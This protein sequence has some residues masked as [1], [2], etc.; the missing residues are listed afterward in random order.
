[1]NRFYMILLAPL[2]LASS[3]FATPTACAPDTLAN[4]LV[5]PGGCTINSVLFNQWSYASAS[6]LASSIEVTPITTPGDEGFNFNSLWVVTNT[7]PGV[8]LSE[9][10]TIG[11][12]ASG[13]SFTDLSLS[14]PADSVSGS[15]VA[16]VT[17]SYCFNHAVA[18]CPLSI[19]PIMVINPPPNF[20]DVIFASPE[21]SISVLK[22][23]GVS[24]GGIGSAS[25]SQ[26]TN[27]FSS[28]EPV[29]FVLLGSGLLGLGLLRKR[30][31]R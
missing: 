17:E 30:I 27:Q 13:A 23:I 26:V 3:A 19:A 31:K 9:D 20:S 8:T 29:S 7:T 28:P 24:T 11:F 2:V 10:S 1:M 18:G 14:M 25:I 15:G 5:L 22:D 16:D 12:T 4:Y 6:V 21:T